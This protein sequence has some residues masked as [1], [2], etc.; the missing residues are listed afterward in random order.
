MSPNF[1]PLDALVDVT[2]PY[3]FIGFGVSYV[4]KP[5]EFIWFGA[6]Y[7]TKPYEYIRFGAMDDTRHYKFYTLLWY[8]GHQTL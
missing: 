1:K 4:T 8:G 7:V 6:R 2:Q 3:K 5:Y